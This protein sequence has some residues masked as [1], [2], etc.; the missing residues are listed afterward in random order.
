MGWENTDRQINELR[1]TLHENN[2]KFNKETEIIKKEPKRNSGA[3][4]SN[5]WNEKCNKELQ[6]RLDQAEEGINKLKD[7]WN[8]PEQKKRMKKSE[9]RLRDRWDTL[10]WTEN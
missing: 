1:K 3:E 9:K 10:T 6:S 5:E 8:F 2:K 7:S 4:E